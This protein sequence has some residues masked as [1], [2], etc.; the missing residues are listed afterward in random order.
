[1]WWLFQLNNIWLLKRLFDIEIFRWTHFSLIFWHAPVVLEIKLRAG[2]PGLLSFWQL[3]SIYCNHETS[4]RTISQ[5]L[6][7]CQHAIFG[8]LFSLFSGFGTLGL[9]TSL[10]AHEKHS[11]IKRTPCQT[12]CNNSLKVVYQPL[13]SLKNFSCKPNDKGI[14]AWPTFFMKLGCTM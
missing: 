4:F 9:L 13:Q 11:K 12:R 14:L 3:L 10:P 6:L 5:I 1:M 2:K 8:I 7:S